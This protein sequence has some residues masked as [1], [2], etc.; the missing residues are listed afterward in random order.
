[1]GAG[2]RPRDGGERPVW[3]PL[4]L[5]PEGQAP[6]KALAINVERMNAAI[7]AAI[8]EAP[9]QWIWTHRRFKTRPRGA[10]AIYP[11]RRGWLRRLRHAL[12]GAR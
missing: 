10:E 12:R 6:D 9:E 11:P 7:E 3:P 4:E 1:M 2:D 5:E 8:R